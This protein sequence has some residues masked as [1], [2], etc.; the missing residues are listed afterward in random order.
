MDSLTKLFKT[1][2]GLYKDKI[3]DNNTLRICFWIFFLSGINHIFHLA[4]FVFMKNTF[5]SIWN[6]LGFLI[7]TLLLILL[8]EKNALSVF[9]VSNL[10]I[11]LYS[12]FVVY[13]IGWGF[14]AQFSLFLMM[15][16]CPF[17]PGMTKFWKRIVFAFNLS[18]FIIL[19]IFSRIPLYK[20]KEYYY[21]TLI[22]YTSFVNMII[23]FGCMYF[24][25]KI[26]NNTIIKDNES[27]KNSNKTLEQRVMFDPNTGILNREAFF[28]SLKIAKKRQLEE[29]INYVI[30]FGDLDDFKRINDKFGHD[31]GNKVLKS[32]AD[33]IKKESKKTDVVARWGGEE[34]V[35]LLND[36]SLNDAVFKTEKLRKLISTIKIEKYNSLKISITFGVFEGVRKMSIEDEI[37][38][39]DMLMYEGKFKG[40]NQVCF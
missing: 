40:K 38:H 13:F 1:L 17:V 19:Y 20:F 36:I 37:I 24:I 32:V 27:L 34:F 18:L 25:V 23:L 2:T 4:V 8:K 5:F 28:E 31:V 39:A 12:I 29:N 15:T 7:L 16:L 6:I 30:V 33:T 10:E 14:N 11:A 3:Q 35:I 21:S 26:T 9:L 22:Q